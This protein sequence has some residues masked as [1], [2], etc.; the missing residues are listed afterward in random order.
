[1]NNDIIL[2]SL[3]EIRKKKNLIEE[4]IKQNNINLNNVQIKHKKAK[5]NYSKKCQLL[6]GYYYQILI[7]A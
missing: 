6:S 2:Q 5:E 1:M 7:R 4:K 3:T